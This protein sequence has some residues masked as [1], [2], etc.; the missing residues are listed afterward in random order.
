MAIRAAHI[1]L[2]DFGQDRA[3]GFSIGEP[4]DLGH[5]R[6]GVPMIE[7]EQQG[8]VFAAVHACVSTDVL[9]QPNPIL[10]PVAAHPRDFTREVCLP[11]ALVVT[12]AIFGLTRAATRLSL[13]S[14]LVLKC[15]IR[16]GLEHPHIQHRSTTRLHEVR[17]V[18]DRPRCL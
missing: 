5:L 6:F 13:A 4:G 12:A 18:T 2:L 9:E 15:K 3:P 14:C 16:L 11:V 1:A 17:R 8:I 7:F 10:F